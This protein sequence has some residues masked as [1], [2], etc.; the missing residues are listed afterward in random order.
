MEWI[1]GVLVSAG[2]G[3][4]YGEKMLQGR[5]VWDPYR[6]KLGALFLLTDAVDLEPDMRVLYLG[7]AHGTTVSH[8]ADYVDTVYA[9]EFSP[10]PMRDLLEVAR[11]RT[12]IVPFMADA[13]EP[14]SYAPL[15]EEVD[16]VYQDVAQ[17]DQV[18]IARKNSIFLK[19]GGTCIIMLKTRSIDVTRSPA[20]ILAES[21]S[22]LENSG[23]QPDSSVWLLPY[24][25]DHAAV[26][27]TKY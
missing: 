26:L 12:N 10:Q 8:L 17:R 14:S 21:L 4:V 13:A 2:P 9:V 7:A 24:H 3:G 22:G 5:R 23:L 16:F 11:R 15:V 25:R 6:S 19:P 20:T 1:D 27:C 18:G